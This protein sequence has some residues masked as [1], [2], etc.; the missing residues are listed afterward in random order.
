MTNKT[1]PLLVAACLGVF[2]FVPAGAQE[3]FD[4]ENID[5]L[6]EENTLTDVSSR[7]AAVLQNYLP[8]Q[9]L[10]MGYTSSADFLNNRA[11]NAEIQ[12]LRALKNVRER[13]KDVNAKN[14]SES[15]QVDFLLLKNALNETIRRAGLNRA[16]QDPL[17]Y[18]EALDAV[19]D[20]YLDD[21]ISPAKKRADISARMAALEDTANQAEKNLSKPSAFLAQ[22][23]MEKAYYAYLSFD[24][25]TEFLMQGAQDDFAAADTK[26]SAR[27]AKR[28]VKRM[29]DLFKT[30]SQAEDGRDF[31]L[32]EE[33]YAQLL[34]G[35]Y[36]IHT[37]TAKLVK[38]LESNTQ[39]ARRNLSA[40][41]EV[42]LAQTDAEDEITLVEDLNGAPQETATEK[43]PAKKKAKKSKPVLRNA[44]DFYAVA[45]RISTPLQE[46]DFP[47]A[48]KQQAEQLASDLMQKNILPPLQTAVRVEPAPQYYAYTRAFVL[49]PSYAGADPRFFLRLP[50]GN[51]LAKEEQL[52]R[53]FNAPVLKLLTVKQLVPG[54]Y[55]QN[56]SGKNW[57]AWRRAYPSKTTANGWREY[58]AR[59]AKEQNYLVTD[60]ELLFFAWDEYLRALAAETDV[61]LQ[62]KR[63]SYA[64]ALA[65]LTQE[66]GLEQAEAE[67][68]LKELAAEPGEAVSRQEGLEIWQ[69][70]H[71]KMRKKL[72]KKFSEADF[73][74]K[75]LQIGNVPPQSVE[76]ELSRLYEKDKKKKKD[77]F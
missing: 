42:F 69:N 47:A 66:N 14:L 21:S 7:Y 9:A 64:D 6:L 76:A 18:A 49:H 55:F 77:L 30:L 73:H 28:S 15:K 22:L 13:L 60:D 12:T 19:Y 11:D 39:S 32:G 71:E 56:T 4:F 29:F 3:A 54:G 59:L 8:E 25:I 68:M 38:K 2:A 67:E 58:A 27:A 26:N 10:R 62:T 51:T 46:N 53:D 44:Q 72:G 48:L 50:A 75:A 35:G 37:P 74:R 36:Q 31:R 16:Q 17:Y 45:K 24:E 33:A 70:A 5:S 43:K 20:V 40:A 1:L 34:E 65:Y 61:K 41:L 23:A 57:S 63:F 52:K